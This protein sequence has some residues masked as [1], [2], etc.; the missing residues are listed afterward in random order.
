MPDNE[1][2]VLLKEDVLLELRNQL[3]PARE[4]ILA[5]AHHAGFGDGRLRQWRQHG[6]CHASGGPIGFGSLGFE[7]VHAMPFTCQLQGQ[8]T[9]HQACAQN[10]NV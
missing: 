10:G 2:A 4:A 1:R 7:H 5:H 3:R 8:Q 9:A 6:C